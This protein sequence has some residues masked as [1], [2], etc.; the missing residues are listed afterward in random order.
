MFHHALALPVIQVIPNKE[1]PDR[2]SFDAALHEALVAAGTEIVCLA[3][4][5]RILTGMCTHMFFEGLMLLYMMWNAWLS[6]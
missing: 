2:A 3:G 4:F 5:M 6:D 1:F